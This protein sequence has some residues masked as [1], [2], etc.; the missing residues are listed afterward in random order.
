MSEAQQKAAAAGSRN[1]GPSV[2]VPNRFTI[3]VSGDVASTNPF[4]AGQQ[5]GTRWPPNLC[6]RFC[7]THRHSQV[8]LL[9]CIS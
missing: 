7:L 4:T 1:G 8:S 6:W 3:P 2:D 9:I 5:T